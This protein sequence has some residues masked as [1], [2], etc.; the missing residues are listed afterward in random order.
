MKSTAGTLLLYSALMM[1]SFFAAST[2]EAQNSQAPRRPEA[3]APLYVFL[4]IGQSNMAG[5]APIEKEDEAPLTGC[6]LFTDTGEWETAVN[7]LNRYSK[8]RKE[9]GM[10][11]LNPGYTFAR[12]LSSLQPDIKIG[13]VVSAR[14]GT[15]INEW[16]PGC[17][18]YEEAVSRARQA[19]KT[20]VLKAILWHQ[21]ETDCN[22]PDYLDKLKIVIQSLRADLG[23]SSLPFIAGQ[24][25][26]D[27]NYP[28]NEMIASLPDEVPNTAYA[29]SEGLTTLDDWHFD[30]RSMR[31]LGERYADAVLPFLGN[32]RT[33]SN[34]S[35]QA[36]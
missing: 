13:L 29:S 9:I 19:G 26:Y 30:T 34:A 3:G 36:K 11:Q 25:R 4:L 24:I 23:D 28:V 10:Q 22:D 8:Y 5:R 32:H 18:L 27:G 16:Q 20:G 7:P 35:K 2:G 15:S 1:T 33:D 17:D 21:G 14:G 12:R 31:I 6:Y